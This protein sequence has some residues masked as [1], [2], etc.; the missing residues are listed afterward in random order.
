MQILISI[1]YSMQKFLIR[2]PK[3]L[4]QSNKKQK[5]ETK[6]KSGV[7][8]T[9]MYID[10]GQKSFGA[11]HRCKIC[12]MMFVVNDVEDERRHTRFCQNVSVLLFIHINIIFVLT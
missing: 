8:G 10:L 5:V 12:E 7:S 3:A 1:T 11:T 4:N 2:L 6:P 9:Q